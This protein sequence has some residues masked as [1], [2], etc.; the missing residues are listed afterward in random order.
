MPSYTILHQAKDA[1]VDL[2]AGG[3]ADDGCS[4][5]VERSVCRKLLLVIVMMMMGGS[6]SNVERWNRV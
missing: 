2:E 5:F 4:A 1:A 6:S 3:E